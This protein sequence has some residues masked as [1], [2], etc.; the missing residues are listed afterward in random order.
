MNTDQRRP[1]STD[2]DLDQLA[3]QVL[4]ALPDHYIGPPRLSAARIRALA[5]ERQRHVRR[6]RWSITAAAAGVVVLALLI[7]GY[8]WL[9]PARPAKLLPAAP[10]PPVAVPQPL[11][12]VGAGQ[13]A[14]DALKALATAAGR[15]GSEPQV[16]RYAYVHTQSWY[17]DTTG[18]HRA[19][20]VQDEKL[21]WDADRTGRQV[22]TPLAALPP[23][24]TAAG[25]GRP[26]QTSYEGDS[27]LAVNVMKPSSEPALLAA[28][29]NAVEP[30]TNGPQAVVRGVVDLY[31]YHLLTA[32][33]RAAALTVLA[34]TNGLRSH[35]T[36][37]DRAG[38]QALAVSVD[39]DNATTH[40]IVLF[41]P[42]TGRLLQYERSRLRSGGL[43]VT[44]YTIFL[45]ASRTDTYNS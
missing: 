6:Q 25:F 3:P 41:D 33:Q 8:S 26:R 36:I 27:R 11:P 5:R 2:A 1:T 10:P 40:D 14:R 9:H 35:G 37:T 24:S 31:R 19:P 23:A 13:P 21:W 20:T 38:R 30:V 4:N 42:T 17:A 43:S 18:P 34:N 12:V 32:Q 15:S 44:D 29:L 7:Q 39:S 22:I 45:T 28:Q 16:G